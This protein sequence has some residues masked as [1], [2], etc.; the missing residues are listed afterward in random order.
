MPHI[1]SI[2]SVYKRKS[3]P[4]S[5]VS[6]EKAREILK[7]GSVHGHPLT[8]KQRGMFGAAAGRD[9]KSI[10]LIYRKSKG[11]K[12]TLRKGVAG[13]S[14]VYVNNKDLEDVKKLAGERGLEARYVGT[15][16][17]LEKVRLTGDEKAM[18]EVARQY[19][20]PTKTFRRGTKGIKS[21]DDAIRKATRELMG[22][23]PARVTKGPG[24]IH[25][26]WGGIR[27]D[28][29]SDIVHDFFEDEGYTAS[30]AIVTSSFVSVTFP[31]SEDR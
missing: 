15:K 9:R 11:F 7:D 25:V 2:R 5:N 24:E 1:K 19:G 26:R 12:R 6:P 27:T 29:K 16:N 23:T 8:E 18:D 17:G 22:N 10:R 30:N 28:L 3:Q 21:L 14:M 31:A 13:S 4:S 20:R